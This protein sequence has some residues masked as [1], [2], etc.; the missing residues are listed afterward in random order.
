MGKKEGEEVGRWEVEKVRQNSEVGR[1]NSEV[2][3]RKSGKKEDGIR[4]GGKTGQL[5]VVQ[6][7]SF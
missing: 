6:L 7:F 3:M 5:Q 4:K 2:G 1:W